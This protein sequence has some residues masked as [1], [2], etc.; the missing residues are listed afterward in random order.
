MQVAGLQAEKTLLVSAEARTAAEAAS[1]AE[2]RMRLS[3]ALAAT[4]ATGEMAAARAS[5]ELE[6]VTAEKGRLE[7]DWAVA[8]GVC[9]NPI[10]LAGHLSPLRHPAS[11]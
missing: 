10:A 6:R 9:P 8:Q 4:K 7:K 1:A 5:A 11:S 2:E 3:S